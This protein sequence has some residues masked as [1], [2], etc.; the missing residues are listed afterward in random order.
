MVYGGRELE[1]C[2]FTNASFQYDK[3]D[4]KLQ[5]GFMFTLNGSI[6]S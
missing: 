5:C 1:V 6:G 4:R 3:D 2:E